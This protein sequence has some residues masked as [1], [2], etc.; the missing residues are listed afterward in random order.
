MRH[1]QATCRAI[2]LAG[3]LCAAC[4]GE[5]ARSETPRAETSQPDTT[6]LVI[7]AL[8][9]AIEAA[10]VDLAIPGAAVAV[11]T[12]SRVLMHQ[13]FGM[14]D[15]ARS[16][17]VTGNTLFAIGSC[18]KPFTALAA[19]ISQDARVLSLDDHPREHL[20]YFAL[21]D[22]VANARASLRDLLS[23]RTGVPIDDRQGWYERYATREALIRMAMNTAPSKP[24]RRAF[25]YNNFMYVAAG[26]AIA[27]AHHATYAEVLRRLILEPVGM[28]RT[29]TSLARVKTSD[30][31]SL[32]YSG[33]SR[34]TARQPIEP[35]R[36][37]WLDGIEAAGGIWSSAE[38]MSRWLRMLV[39]GGVIDGRRVLSDSA[40]RALLTPAV[41]AGASQY[42]LGWFIEDW[43]GVTL[44]THAGGVSG[45]GA[46][47][48]FAPALGLGWAVLTNVDD[49]AL[50][51]AIREL[52]YE[53][54]ARP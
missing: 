53:R 16:L 35:S 40:L 34:A 19:A 48:E 26:E 24:F 4:G 27:A 37:F 29:T 43:H 25:Q 50:P 6:H 10:R 47:C 38:D 41:R 49:G 3:A 31:V 2:L 45:F 52:I 15:V 20:P 5:Q 23:H 28:T 8:A 33:R 42:G 21:R 44:Y 36:L 51:G 14:R 46:R 32:G 54:L 22:S 12:D 9:S 13:G 7:A 18:T 1:H 30:D 11:V 17:P 39:G